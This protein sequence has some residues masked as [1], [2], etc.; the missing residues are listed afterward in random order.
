MASETQVYDVTALI[1][2]QGTEGDVVK[3][4]VTLLYRTIHTPD[5]FQMGAISTI[6]PF[7]N[8]VKKKWYLSVFSEIPRAEFQGVLTQMST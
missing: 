3:Q 1:G 4:L 7:Y 8:P 6:Q 5:W 2:N